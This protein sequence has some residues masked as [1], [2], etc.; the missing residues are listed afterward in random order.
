MA[1]GIALAATLTQLPVGIWVLAAMS[2]AM[3]QQLMGGDW[4]ATLLFGGSL[5]AALGLMH[6]LA[7]L[8]LG[9][10]SRAAAWRAAALMATTVILMSA[11]LH[12]AR[13]CLGKGQ[14]HFAQG[15]S[16]NEP[17]PR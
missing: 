14:A 12:R 10:S 11:T 3:Q 6:H 2:P 4:P 9:E 7:M 1:G 15:A 16:Q 17:V 8:A 13:E 5:L